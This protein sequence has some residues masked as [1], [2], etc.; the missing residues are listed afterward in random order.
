METE[1]NG[2]ISFLDVRINNNS[3]FTTSVFHK[4]TYTGLLLNYHSFTSSVYKTGL[5]KCLGG[6]NLQTELIPYYI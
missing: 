1:V 5:V 6:Q 2:I 4:S 3:E